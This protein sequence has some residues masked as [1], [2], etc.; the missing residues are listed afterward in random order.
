MLND[1]EKSY[2]KYANHKANEIMQKRMAE[3]DKKHPF[4]AFKRKFKDKIKWLL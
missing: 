4:K 2:L 3:Y 1:M